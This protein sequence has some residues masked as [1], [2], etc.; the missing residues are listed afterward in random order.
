MRE[1]KNVLVLQIELGGKKCSEQR[2]KI[3]LSVGS[4]REKSQLAPFAAD[5]VGALA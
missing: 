4:K 5:N 1:G 3:E 2:M